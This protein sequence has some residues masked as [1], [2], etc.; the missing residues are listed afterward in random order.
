MKKV[1][2]LMEDKW[3]KRDV[4]LPGMEAALGAGEF[5][6]AD[7]PEDI[8]WDTL[9]RDVS[10]F[11][12]QKG[13]GTELPDGSLLNWITEERTRRLWDYVNTGG[14]LLFIHSGTVLDSAGPLYRKL[15]GGIFLRHPEQCPVTYA[16]LRNGHPVVE[17]VEPFTVPDEHYY[18]ELFVEALHPLMICGSAGNPAAIAGWYQEFGAGRSVSLTPG[19]TLEA[20]LNPNMTRLIGNAVKWLARINA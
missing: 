5:A 10:L 12:S 15:V 3:H 16:P 11:V 1:Y 20:V 8:P 4:I 9:E 6:A 14:G 17:G 18:C 19:H 2:L 7:D 13:N